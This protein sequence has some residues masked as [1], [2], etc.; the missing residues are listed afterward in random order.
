[1]TRT[2]IALT[3]GA[4]GLAGVLG[5]AGCGAAASPTNPAPAGADL[6][7]E[8]DA[9]QAL[10]FNTGL[11][12]D[13]SPSAP[14]P[15]ASA[16][17]NANGPAKNRHPRIA[18]RRFLSRNVLHGEITVQT[19]AGVRTVVVQRGTVTAVSATTV[20]VRSTDG[21]TLAWTFGANL[22]VVENLHKVGPTALKTGQKIGVAGA[23]NGSATDARLIVIAQAS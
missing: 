22:R 2:R 23:Q 20:E 9:L 6:S 3:L 18:E 21:F 8:A 13:P 1:M 14:A 7:A 16:A 5:L 4:L 11:A 19:K 12:A 15:G 10:G 17:P